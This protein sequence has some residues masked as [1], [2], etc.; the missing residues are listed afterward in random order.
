MDT[1]L[2]L[3]A[4]ELREVVLGLYERGVADPGY[5]EPWYAEKQLVPD[6]AKDPAGN[7][8]EAL[9]DRT[10]T[11]AWEAVS[12][13][14]FFNPRED[15]GQRLTD[16]DDPD[17]PPRDLDLSPE[18]VSDDYPGDP[19]KP[20]VAPFKPGRNDPCPCGSGKKYK[21]CCGK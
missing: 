9:L 11:D 12:G 19:P 8:S 6:A 4:W 15:A 5:V 10:I 1:A 18:Q 20:Y 13:W 14:E 3:R 21:K 2:L 17:L 7:P 16:S